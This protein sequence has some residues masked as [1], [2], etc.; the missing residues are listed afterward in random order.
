MRIDF[1]PSVLRLWDLRYINP[2]PARRRSSVVKSTQKSSQ[3]LATPLSMSSADPTTYLQTRRPRGITSLAE[4]SP[5]GT[6]PSASAGLLFALSTDSRIHTFDAR[7]LAP[8]SG[9]SASDADGD[10]HAPWTFGHPDLHV[11]SFYPRMSVSPCGRWLACGGSQG[12]SVFLFDTAGG[13]MGGK[14]CRGV[15]LTGQKGEVGAVDWATPDVGLATCADDGTVRV[16]RED[17]DRYQQC[18]EEPEEMKWNWCWSV[19]DE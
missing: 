13:K 10:A 11:R 2:K 17:L 12:G 4:A 19:R 14:A 8:L 7:T 16:W 6:M 15:Q 1:A 18:C 3:T 5:N 9:S